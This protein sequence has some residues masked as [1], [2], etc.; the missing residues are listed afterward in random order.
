MCRDARG[1]SPNPVERTHT[2]RHR[3]FTRE[4]ASRRICKVPHSVNLSHKTVADTVPPYRRAGEVGVPNCTSTGSAA[5][6]PLKM[7]PNGRWGGIPQSSSQERQRPIAERT[8][9]FP[10]LSHHPSSVPCQRPR[11]FLNEHGEP[12]SISCFVSFFFFFFYLI[13]PLAS[14]LFGSIRLLSLKVC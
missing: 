2:S 3:S 5:G 7:R 6:T 8:S 10:A 14:S 13:P 1:V 4:R 12:R 11:A 9:D